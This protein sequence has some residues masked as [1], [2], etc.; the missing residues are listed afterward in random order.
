MVADHLHAQASLLA[1]DLPAA[2]QP[3]VRRVRHV[4]GAARRG[5]G[6]LVAACEPGMHGLAATDRTGRLP[7]RARGGGKALPIVLGGAW[8]VVPPVRDDHVRTGPVP[9]MPSIP[10]R[11]GRAGHVPASLQPAQSSPGRYSPPAVTALSRALA[12]SS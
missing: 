3:G 12:C 10:G 7:A 1:G 2:G 8:L 6:A 9:M 5:S 11:D 4:L